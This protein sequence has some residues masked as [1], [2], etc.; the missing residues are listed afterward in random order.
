MDNNISRKDAIKNI[1]LAA[2]GMSLLPFTSC[3]SPVNSDGKTNDEKVLSQFYIP[4]VDPLEPGIVGI[5]VRTIIRSSQTNRQFSSVEMAVASRHMGPPPHFHE[6]L[7]ELMYVLEGTATVMVDG[8]TEDIHAGGW[9]LRP[10]KLEHTY[11]NAT[12]KTLR[13]IDM[14]FNQNLEDFLEELYTKIFPEMIKN[15]LT[16]QDP[17]IEKRLTELDEKFGITTFPE[18]RKPLADKY[19]LIV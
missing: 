9:H 14:Y 8:K 17:K 12:D 1:G 16:P 15:N 2:F 3:S 11:W 19:G 18:K 13:F 7:D 10:R 4:P 5:N 6:S